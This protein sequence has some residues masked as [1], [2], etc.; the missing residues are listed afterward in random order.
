MTATRKRDAKRPGDELVNRLQA[1][2]YEYE[3]LGEFER[4]RPHLLWLM[5][6]ALKD[7]PSRA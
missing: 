6:I 7:S 5:E 1:L 4:A 3:T 2:L